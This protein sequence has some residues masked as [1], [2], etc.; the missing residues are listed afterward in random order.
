M[1]YDLML[2]LLKDE[3]ESLVSTIYQTSCNI[4]DSKD[5]LNTILADKENTEA[6]IAT[7]IERL[8]KIKSQIEEIDKITDEVNHDKMVAEI[9]LL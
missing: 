5:R 2:E 1:N 3:K 8:T 9:D 7:Y 4:I 6:K